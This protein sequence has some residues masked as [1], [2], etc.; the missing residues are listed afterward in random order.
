MI[1]NHL[2]GIIGFPLTHS[3][4]PTY[5]NQKFSDLN[6]LDHY[7]ET[8][9][10]P[11]IEYLNNI[12]QSHPNLR[13]L[14]VTVPHKQSVI[15]FL[16]HIDS[17]A[18]EVGAVNSIKVSNGKMHG[19]NTD[20]YAFEIS[21]YDLINEHLPLKALVLGNGGASRAVQYVLRKLEIEFQVVSRTKR[22]DTI[23]Y[24]EVDHEMVNNHDLIINTTTL[25]MFPK[26]HYKPYFPYHALNKNH[27][28]FDLI[29][30]PNETLFLYEG[31]KKGCKTKNGLDMLQ[32]QSEKSW[33][34]WNA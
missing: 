14:S 17:V 6:L 32:L 30:N 23:M 3:F 21:L 22:D 18:L 11:Q 27:L 13:G 31:R 33:E 4:S 24:E 20:A 1:I 10:I 16:D 2:Y 12:I 15:P 26:N 28:L 5:F 29:Y 34:I 7:F 9:E 25:G 8:F 19:F